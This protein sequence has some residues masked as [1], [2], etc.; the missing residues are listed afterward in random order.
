M[1]FGSAT[2]TYGYD[3]DNRLI[4][5]SAGSLTNTFAYDYRSRRYYR[6]T[7]PTNH[8]FCVFDGCLSIQE[9]ESEIT[10]RGGGC[11]PSI[12]FSR[13]R[14]PSWTSAPIASQ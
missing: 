14:M 8:M 7:S 4:Q 10:D 12:F 5:A 1:A 6:S 3:F 2:T 11:Q 13:M 9:S